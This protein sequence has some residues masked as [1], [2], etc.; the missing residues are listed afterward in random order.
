MDVCVVIRFRESQNAD[1]ARLALRAGDTLIAHDN[2]V[3]KLGFA[4][5]AN[6]AARSGNGELILFLNPDATPANDAFD[7]LEASFDD[8]GVVAADANLGEESPS[9]GPDGIPDWLSGACLAVRREAFERVGGFDERLFMYCEDVDLSY[10]LK[11]YGRLV[12]CADALVEHKA[13]QRP[14]KALHRNFRNWLVVQRRHRRA[15][16]VRMF[17]DAIWAL[18]QR[19]WKLCAA[20]LT[21]LLDYLVRARRWA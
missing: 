3:E 14:F 20:R 13:G 15:R 4:A 2:T 9:L 10:K 11:P 17:R 21:G 12:H 19:Q 16:P 8:P 18:R 7:R 6:A 1:S 5:A